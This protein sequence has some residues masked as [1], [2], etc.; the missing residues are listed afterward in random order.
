M[1]KELRWEPAN[2]PAKRTT[3]TRRTN[4]PEPILAP[5]RPSNYLIPLRP[6]KAS[7]ASIPLLV[8]FVSLGLL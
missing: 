4:A 7:S 6:Q 5:A 2:Q 1:G 3:K 8:S